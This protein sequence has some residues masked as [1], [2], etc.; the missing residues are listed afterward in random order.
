MRCACRRGILR[1]VGPEPTSVEAD[2]LKCLIL[3][4]LMMLGAVLAMGLALPLLAVF[5]VLL[6]AGT[7][8]L[9]I[10]L[11]FSLIWLCLRLFAGLIVGIGAVLLCALGFGALF[12]GGAVILA[13]G[14]AMTHLLLPLLVILGIVWL[15]QRAARPAP[16]LPAPHA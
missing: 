7:V 13:L 6:A 3:F 12:A 11:A 8:I 5:P 9:P 1:I 10:V 15:I 4:P 14:V 2:M 16:V